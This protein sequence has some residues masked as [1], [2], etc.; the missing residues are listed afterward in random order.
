MGVWGYG[1]MG[2][3]G[4]GGMGIWGYGGMARVSTHVVNLNK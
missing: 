4:Y 3:W 1:G 2:V